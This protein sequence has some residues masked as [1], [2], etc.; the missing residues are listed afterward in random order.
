[1][2]R[3]RAF[4]TLLGGAAAAWPIAARGQQADRVRR[5]GVL[6]ALDEHDAE[7][8]GWLSRFKQGLAELGWTDDHNLR[9][10]VR[11][12]AGSVD[13]MRRLAKDLVDTQPDLILS[14]S[15][16]VT[17]ALK[18]ETQTIPIVFAIVADPVGEGFVANLARPGGNITGFINVE[19]AMGS[20]WL[21]LLTEIAPGVKRVAI[22]FNPDTAP[23]HGTYF[24]PA[25]E[26]AAG[27]LKINSFVAPVHSDAEIETTISSVGREP[28]GGIVVMT[29]L[30]MQVHRAPIILHSARKK[31]PAIYA[32]AI[33]ARD[34]GLVSYGADYADIFHRAATYVDRIFKGAQPADLP[35][36][37]PTKFEMAV[38]LKTARA[39]GLEVPASMQ[40]VADE[41]IE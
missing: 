1:M 38:N 24:L 3:R 22:M 16:P 20:K 13:R 19:A 11:W 35:V 39:L 37:L 33:S 29:D 23:G 26:N 8:Q 7:P 21:E 18:R 9:L 6:I 30:F 10:D 14:Q 28:A 4:I 2:M 40:Q 25:I 34:G 27:L 17:A 41:V 32:E 31:V 36:Q 12:G 15:T 5:I